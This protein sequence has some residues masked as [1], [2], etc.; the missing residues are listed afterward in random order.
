MSVTVLTT[1]CWRPEAWSLCE[2]YV[3]RQT[4]KP[5]QWLV[6]D[7]DEISTVCT[8]GQEYHHWPECR[9][10]GSL[11]R[12]I[13]RAIENN[14]IKGDILVIV[15]ND[16]W[17]APDWIEFCLDGLKRAQLFGEGRA[18]YYTVRGRYWFTHV[19]LTHAS[20]CSTAMT[21][22][23]Y[24]LLLKQCMA[25]DEPFVDYLFWPKAPCD[26]LVADPLRSPGRKRRTIGIKAMPGRVGYGGGHRG[27]DRSAKD[28]LDL[29]YL[30]S[31][32][33]ADADAYAPFYDPASVQKA[34]KNLFVAPP[35]PSGQRLN[36]RQMHELWLAKNPR[37][38]QSQ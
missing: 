20:L 19:N 10:R 6:L 38:T 29:S 31:L 9:G 22:A 24:P 27:R 34:E 15:E 4:V 14:L 25:S 33:G 21:R 26:K 17:Y 16:D 5:D 11:A 7:D 30:R 37:K 28:D 3:G 8:M 2:K 13:R 12:K 36:A 32:I 18:L 1:A 35:S 23:V